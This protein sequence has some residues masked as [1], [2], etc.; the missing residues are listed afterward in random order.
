MTAL[1]YHQNEKAE[2][3][4]IEKAMAPAA[5]AKTEALGSG[6]MYL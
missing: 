6:G 2:A 4:E 1:E 5:V 3:D